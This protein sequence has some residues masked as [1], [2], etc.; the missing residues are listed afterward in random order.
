MSYRDGKPVPGSKSPYTVWLLSEDNAVVGCD[1]RE[2]N[3]AIRLYNRALY[4]YVDF[5]S[6]FS[7]YVMDNEYSILG[8]DV[9]W[10][11]HNVNMSKL[12]YIK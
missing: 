8:Y 7:S 2:I 6:W 3:K 5:W 9:L 12:L 1:Y 4:K 10:N 11:E